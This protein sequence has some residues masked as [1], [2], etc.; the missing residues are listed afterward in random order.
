MG[1]E[2]YKIHNIEEQ[3]LSVRPRNIIQLPGPMTPYPSHRMQVP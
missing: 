1:T 2:R 3:K